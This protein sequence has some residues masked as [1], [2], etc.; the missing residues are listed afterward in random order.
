MAFVHKVLIYTSPLVGRGKPVPGGE[1]VTWTQAVVFLLAVAVG[2]I[3]TEEK[4]I[5][6]LEEL[7]KKILEDYKQLASRGAA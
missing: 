2:I 3:Y 5:A 6:M 1:E 7:N 4:T